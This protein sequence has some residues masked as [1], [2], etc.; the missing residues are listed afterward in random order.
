MLA[1][2]R[3]ERG[4]GL[5]EFALVLIPLVL[6]VVAVLQAGIYFYR[7][8]TLNDAVR[9]AA[10]T[11]ITCRYT[12]ANPAAAGDNAANGLSVTWSGASC[13]DVMAAVSGCADPLDQ[14][15]NTVTVTGTASMGNLG[16]P[17]L[18]S[19]FPSTSTRSVSVV[20]N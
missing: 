5:V 10:R 13:S 17:I 18:G 1:R 8:I 6:I 20:V 12:S 19:I 11:A 16:F 7:E 2:L 14:T 4:Q 15:C 9:A 3:D